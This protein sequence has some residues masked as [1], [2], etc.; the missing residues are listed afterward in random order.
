MRRYEV[1]RQESTGFDLSILCPFVLFLLGNLT[2]LGNLRGD[3]IVIFPA[4]G[5][6]TAGAVL[7]TLRGIGKIAAAIFS[8][9]VQGTVA[10][11]AAEAFRIGIGVAG[12][13]FAVFILKKIIIGHR[14]TSFDVLR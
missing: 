10:K 1:L 3:G 8:Q 7:K 2:N 14:K 6:Q 4:V 12:E 13:I 9:C 5:A 11:Q